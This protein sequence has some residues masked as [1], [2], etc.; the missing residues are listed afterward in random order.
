MI[1]FQ[2]HYSTAQDVVPNSAGYV[3]KNVLLIGDMVMADAI[4]PSRKDH[5][6][7]K[8]QSGNYIFNHTFYPIMAISSLFL[9]SRYQR[10]NANYENHKKS[11]NDEKNVIKNKID[12]AIGMSLC[13]VGMLDG[14]VSTILDYMYKVSLT[15]TKKISLKTNFF[16]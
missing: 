3:L 11:L 12:K 14:D 5:Q 9:C 7:S 6:R 1:F 4:H 13:G 16:L 2:C 8:T 10:Y 15:E